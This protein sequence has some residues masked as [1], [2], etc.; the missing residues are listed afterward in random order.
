MSIKAAFKPRRRAFTLVEMMMTV[1]VGGILSLA[2]MGLSIYA[3]KTLAGL[4]NYLDLENQ[5]HQALD[6]LSRDARNALAVTAISSNLL[7][8]RSATGSAITYS[9][10]PANRSVSRLEGA[11]QTLLTECDSFNFSLQV[12]RPTNTVQYCD[13]TTATGT[14]GR[15]LS[16]TWSCSRSLLASKV[17]TEAAR[18]AIILIRNA[19]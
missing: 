7:T 18:S 3:A 14:N 2:L 4:D 13:F 9:Y 15:L 8:L 10:S 19:P 1:A 5:S 11:S 12:P 17:N 16:V 6:L